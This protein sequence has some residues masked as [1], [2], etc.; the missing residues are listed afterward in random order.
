MKKS[1]IIIMVIV[2]MLFSCTTTKYVSN[3][4]GLL[5]KYKIGYIVA[6]LGYTGDASLGSMDIEIY[7]LI[8]KTGIRMIGEGEVEILSEEE[9]SK[10]FAIKY[11]VSSSLLESV[12]NISFFDYLTKRPVLNCTGASAWGIKSMDI[13]A[14]KKKALNQMEIALKL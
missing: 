5:S 8:E 3:S 6:P 11:G 14:A 1:H 7:Q 9:K 4:T 2:T 12:V 13:P 10:L